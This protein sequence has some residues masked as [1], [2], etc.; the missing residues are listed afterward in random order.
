MSIIFGKNPFELAHIHS[1]VVVF[2]S[3]FGFVAPADIQTLHVHLP[4]HGFR[5]IRFDEASDVSQIINLTVASMTTGQK[6]NTQHYA[7][8]LRHML[9]KDVSSFQF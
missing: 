9:T 2:V 4:N 5:M 3:D 1:D 7:L 6:A 8:R